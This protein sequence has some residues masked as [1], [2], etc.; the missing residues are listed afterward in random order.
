MNENEPNN[1]EKAPESIPTPE[2]VQSIFEQLIEGKYE[3]E[4]RHDDE[5][6]LYSWDIIVPGE[7]GKTG[8][9][10]RRFP[11]GKDSTAAVHV[12]FYDKEDNPVGGHSVAKYID[13]NWKLTP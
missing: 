1:F 10:Y 7:D 6:G 3:T 13:E 4:R 5:S 12:V 8:Y 2:E 9:E 11:G